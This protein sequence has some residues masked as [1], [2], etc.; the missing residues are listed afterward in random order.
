[1]EAVIEVSSETPPRIHISQSLQSRLGLTPGM[2]LRVEKEEDG[3]VVLEVVTEGAV[4]VDKGGILVARGEPV[5]DLSD[6]VEIHREERI[7]AV[8]ASTY[9]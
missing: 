2:I 8:V 1:M 4:L 5:D 6:V 3:G 7:A 9:P